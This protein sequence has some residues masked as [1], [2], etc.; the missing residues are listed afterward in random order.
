MFYSGADYE[1]VAVP[2]GMPGH[3]EGATLEGL[4]IRP[5]LAMS[6]VRGFRR[7]QGIEEE[8]VHSG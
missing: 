4:R 8:G 7:C 6:Q 1:P 5:A 3:D 2:S